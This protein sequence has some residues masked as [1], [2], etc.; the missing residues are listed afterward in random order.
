MKSEENQLR[1]ARA[2]SIYAALVRHCYAEDVSCYIN[3]DGDEIIRAKLICLEVPDEPVNDIR[4]AEEIAI[5]CHKEDM[6]LPEVYALRKIF[7]QSCHI[8]MQDHMLG[9]YLYV[10]QILHS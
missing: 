7:P 2:R 6:S 1:L 8:P 10:S 4:S 3:N 5:I 9:L